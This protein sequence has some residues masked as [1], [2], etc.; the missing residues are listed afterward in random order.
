M[1]SYNPLWKLLIDKNLSKTELRTSCNITKQTLADMNKNKYVSLKTL[2]K[3]CKY[4]NCNI[5]DVIE[6][7]PNKED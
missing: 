3:I 5:S 2:D 1:F 6:Y 7:I 4:M